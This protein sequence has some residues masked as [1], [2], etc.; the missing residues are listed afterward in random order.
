MLSGAPLA[1]GAGGEEREAS[2]AS[3][4][5][6]LELD[7]EL[8][9]PLPQPS[10]PDGVNAPFDAARGGAQDRL[11]QARG[12]RS[13]E[14]PLRARFRRA[15]A[16]FRRAEAALAAFRVEEALVPARLR[17][18]TQ[19]ERFE[20][21]YAALDGVRIAALRRLLK[22][23]APDPLALAFKIDLVFDEDV[24]SLRGAAL[25]L[26]AIRADAH[27]LARGG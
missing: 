21:R 11:R 5:F 13:S 2:A 16:T 22:T 12:E 3:L 18:G 10:K 23:P 7:R 17:G 6:G 19:G 14:D 8:S 4:P 20:A 15:V 26:A 24:P 9:K 1:L 27:R 25:C